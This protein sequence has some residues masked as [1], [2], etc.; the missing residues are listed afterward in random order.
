MLGQL[1]KISLEELKVK[2]KE[3]AKKVILKP[4]TKPIRYIAGIDVGYDSEQDIAYP[5]IVILKYPELKVIEEVIIRCKV[6]FPYI[7]TFLSFR[8]VPLILEAFKKISIKPDLIMVDGQGLAHP[9]KAGFA[10]HLGVILNL[11]TIG[12]AKKPL[13]KNFKEPKNKKGATSPIYLKNEIVGFVV[14]TKENVK[15]VYVSPGN[16]ITFEEA[17]KF[18]L[19][20]IDKY[21][22]PEPLRKAHNL[23]KKFK[24]S[25]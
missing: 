12:C 24:E 5:A 11:P 8:E 6:K 17:I 18:V 1:N 14:R 7:P 20:T 4:L 23:S 10:V 13:L 22:I 21:R 15:P 3:I 25:S 19:A 9:R 2:Q 16:L